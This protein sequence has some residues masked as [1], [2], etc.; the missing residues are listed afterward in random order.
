MACLRLRLKI[1]KDCVEKTGSGYDSFNFYAY[2][3]F[4][5]NPTVCFRNSLIVRQNVDVTYE[6]MCTCF[7][8]LFITSSI[9]FT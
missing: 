6:N 2:K 1:D 3:D 5:A 8:Y 9:I 7:R 4:Y